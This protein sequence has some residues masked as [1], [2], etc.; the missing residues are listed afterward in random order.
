MDIDNVP[1]SKETF[2]KKRLMFGTVDT[3][4]IWRLTIKRII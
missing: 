2:K 4:L 3:F 1:N